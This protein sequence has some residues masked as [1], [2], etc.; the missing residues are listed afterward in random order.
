[1]AM[2]R[3]I[4]AVLHLLLVCSIVSPLTVE[5]QSIGLEM[6]NNIMPAS[7]GMA[8]ASISNPQ[9]VTSAIY[10][11]P[12]TLTQRQGTQFSFGGA[13]IEPTYNVSVAAPGLPLLGVTPF[14]NAKSDAQGVAGGNIGVTQDFSAMGMPVTVGMGLFA[15]AGVGIDFRHVPESNGTHATIVALDIVNS[16][17]VDL[18]DRLTIGAGLTL[19]SATLDGPFVGVTSSTSDYALRGT[20]GANYTVT[21]EMMLGVYW[22]TKA[23]YT[24]ENLIRFGPPGSAFLDVSVDRPET[25]GFGASNSALMNGRLLLAADVL[26]QQYGDA[27]FLKAIYT[28]QWSIQVG[29]QYAPNRRLKLR[30]GYAWTENL[31]RDLVPNSAGGVTPPITPGA[32]IQ[33]IQAQFAAISQHR[34]T[35]GIGIRDILPGVDFDLFAGGMFGATETFG[36]TTSSLEGYWLGAATTWR[37]GRGAVES[38][39][40]R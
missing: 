17:G 16:I 36:V 30:L 33:Y 15:G 34:V 32:H 37:F 29:A 27:D 38:G 2:S 24:F 35:G 10:G 6:F 3:T 13:W 14:T 4:I 39:D 5:A 40:W 19:S 23:H 31:M 11:N 8:G 7:G 26:F 12:A 28:D 9:D 1:M 18:T 20:L 21:P 25:L 22:R